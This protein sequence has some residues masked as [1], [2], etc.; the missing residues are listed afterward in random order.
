MNR[1]LHWPLY[2]ALL[3][4]IIGCGQEWSPVNLILS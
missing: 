3:A 2:L 4:S 1:L